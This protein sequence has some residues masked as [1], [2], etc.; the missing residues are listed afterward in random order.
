MNKYKLEKSVELAFNKNKGVLFCR[1]NNNYVFIDK[2]TAKLVSNLK[3]LT[4]YSSE[5]ENVLKE[6]E[7]GGFLT[8]QTSK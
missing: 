7:K 8:C 3:I 4:K 2:H 1:K 5:Q 6:L